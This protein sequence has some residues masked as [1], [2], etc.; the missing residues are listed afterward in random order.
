VISSSLLVV[1]G[2]HKTL[3]RNPFRVLYT[4]KNTDQ[5]SLRSLA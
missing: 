5:N 4:S 1:S 2:P 3:M